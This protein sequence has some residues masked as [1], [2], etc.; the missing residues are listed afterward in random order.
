M[1]VKTL[2]PILNHFLVPK[3]EILPKNEADALIK[4]FGVSIEQLPQ[5]LLTDPIIEELEAKK[6]DVI[7][8]TR[9]SYTAGEAVYFRIVA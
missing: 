5:I 1:V 7:K 8:I 2:N 3:H 6:G 4:K 9:K